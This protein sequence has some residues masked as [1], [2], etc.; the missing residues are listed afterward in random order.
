MNAKNQMGQGEHMR[1]IITFREW[2]LTDLTHLRERVVIPTADLTGVT[3]D[4]ENECFDW[5]KTQEHRTSELC[6][7]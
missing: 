7:Q 2:A 4:S 1:L 5:V 3:V 6:F